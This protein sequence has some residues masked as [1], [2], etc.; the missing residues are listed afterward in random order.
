MVY[1]YLKLKELI[2]VASLS[3]VEREIVRSSKIAKEN[4][5]RGNFKCKF[6]SV[7]FKRYSTK[8]K[9]K[10]LKF[11]IELRSDL[12][13]HLECQREDEKLFRNFFPD[14]IAAAVKS[15]TNLH[16]IDYG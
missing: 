10:C 11:A 13:L 2:K 12:R 6:D 15:S 16:I 5:K 1:S 14:L 3:S 4:R 9:V 8:D 7:F